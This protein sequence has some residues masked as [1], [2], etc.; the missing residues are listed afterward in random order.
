[1]HPVCNRTHRACSRVCIACN[2]NG[3]HPAT[4]CTS[5][6]A[7]RIL[8]ATV[9]IWPPRWDLLD[10]HML[11]AMFSSCVK[12]PNPGC[13]AV[14][15]ALICIGKHV[16][17]ICMPCACACACA[18]AWHVHSTCIATAAPPSSSRPSA[19]VRMC[20]CM[21]IR[22]A[23]ASTHAW[24][25][26]WRRCDYGRYTWRRCGYA[27]AYLTACLP[28]N[29]ALAGIYSTHLRLRRAR[30]VLDALALRRPHG[31]TLAVPAHRLTRGRGEGVRGWE[32]RRL[33]GLR[34]FGLFRDGDG[35]R[36]AAAPRPRRLQRR[37]LGVT[38][39]EGLLVCQF[40]LLS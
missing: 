7:V 23:C 13:A 30:H 38:L 29:C 15:L 20:I 35:C 5:P 22:Y 40:A 37:G 4:V 9:R 11:P 24:R 17:S 21:A 18:Y 27:C 33:V 2:R 6:A 32:R 26:A 10:E 34:L 1:M 12:E 19:Q 14:K 39:G 25:Y 31:A 36:R 3:L 16:H 8:P 28:Y